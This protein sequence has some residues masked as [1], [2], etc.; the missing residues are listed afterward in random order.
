[1]ALQITNNAGIFEING[2][3]NAQ[4]VFSLNNH[5]EAL[6]E[7]TKIIT[8]SLNKLIDIDTTAVSAI[9]S[10]YR[11][12]MSNNKVFYIIGQENQRINDRFQTEKLS[13]ILRRDVI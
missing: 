11:K 3:L 9:A 8:L 2:D 6:L 10:L 5:F 1:M 13:Y 12:A 4:N 7:S